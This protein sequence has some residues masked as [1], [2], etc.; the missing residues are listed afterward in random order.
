MV[1]VLSFW[2]DFQAEDWKVG[3]SR[4]GWFPPCTQGPEEG[5]GAE[6]G[7]GACLDCYYSM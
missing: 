4:L 3:D 7:G 5:K 6:G 2:S 1:N